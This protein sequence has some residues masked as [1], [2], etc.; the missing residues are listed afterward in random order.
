M[1]ETRLVEGEDELRQILELQRAN[2]PRSLSAE[3]IA[4]QGFV[5]VEHSLDVLRRMHALAPSVIATEGGRLAGYALVMPIE[6]RELLP[7]L[8][9]MFRRLDGM[10]GV[11]GRYYVMG[12]I[13]V[14]PAWRGRGVFDLLYAA[15]RRHLAGRFDSSITEVATRNVRS[16]R[17]HLRVGFAVIERYRDATDEW[18]V[19]RW[20][21]S[22]RS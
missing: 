17:A 13:C 2:L 15:H 16:M 1:V 9:P 11:L 7:I 14:A 12:Q 22:G 5:T 20:D 6:C 8:E 4:A 19:L 18:A 21:W 10:G 3:E